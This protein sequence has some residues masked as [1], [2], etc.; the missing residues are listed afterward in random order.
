MS[1]GSDIFGYIAGAISVLV[2]FY[3]IVYNQLPKNKVLHLIGLL[4][5]TESLYIR[6]KEEGLLSDDHEFDSSSPTFGMSLSRCRSEADH[7]RTHSLSS[8][9]FTDQVLLWYQLRRR[10]SYAYDNTA[11]IHKDILSKTDEEREC[12]KSRGRLPKCHPR[13]I[14]RTR[15]SPQCDTQHRSPG[16]GPAVPSPPSDKT[17]WTPPTRLAVEVDS[18]ND[19]KLHARLYRGPPRRSRTCPASHFKHRSTAKVVPGNSASTSRERDT[20]A[21]VTSGESS[22]NTLIAE[23][24]NNDHSTT[25]DN[26]RRCSSPLPSPDC[27]PEAPKDA[28]TGAR[29]RTRWSMLRP[30]ASRASAP[31]RKLE[32]T[33]KSIAHTVSHGRKRLAGRAKSRLVAS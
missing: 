21:R 24:S 32:L 4:E 12:L 25:Q 20:H 19:V 17:K 13:Y 30:F 5:D 2:T 7:L 28:E 1:L 10:I 29:P 26:D 22:A 15:I 33:L 27:T 16:P 14:V 9:S 31:A 3:A 23:P 18:E 11:E 8:P 6:S